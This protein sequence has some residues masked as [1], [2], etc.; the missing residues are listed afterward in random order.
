MSAFKVGDKVVVRGVVLS[1][2]GGALYVR[3]PGSALGGTRD[4]WILATGCAPEPFVPAV[5]EPVVWGAGMDIP[6]IVTSGPYWNIRHLDRPLETATVEQRF[7]RPAPD[8]PPDPYVELQAAAEEVAARTGYHESLARLR[9]AV[10]AVKAAETVTG[11]G[12]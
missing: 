8:E 10:D 4:I 12:E 5:G 6:G 9:A 11:G 2:G 3:V 7:I 1:T